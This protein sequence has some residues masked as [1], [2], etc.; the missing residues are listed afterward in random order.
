MRDLVKALKLGIC[1][2]MPSTVLSEDTH[3]AII[4]L[5][6]ADL[7]EGYKATW[8][9]KDYWKLTPFQRKVARLRILWRVGGL[10]KLKREALIVHR[11]KHIPEEPPKLNSREH[12]CHQIVNY[13][14]VRIPSSRLGT[15]LYPYAPS[16]IDKNEVWWVKGHR[17]DLSIVAQPA[18]QYIIK[19]IKLNWQEVRRDLAEY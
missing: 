12:L 7:V 19:Q 18:R 16:N 13:T 11:L 15:I 17:Q 6:G 1:S 2:V 3:K 4:N 5:G 9:I 14:K 10:K 8:W